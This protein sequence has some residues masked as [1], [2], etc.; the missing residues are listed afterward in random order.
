MSFEDPDNNINE[1][2]VYQ[3]YNKGKDEVP[4]LPAEHLYI[5]RNTSF[6]E[7]NITIIVSVLRK[8]GHLHI[9]NHTPLELTRSVYDCIVSDEEQYA[10]ASVYAITKL[11]QSLE[12]INETTHRLREYLIRQQSVEDEDPR[13]I[14]DEEELVNDLQYD[15]TELYLT[16][17]M[18]RRAFV[19]YEGELVV[20]DQGVVS[21]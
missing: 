16:T 8:L 2:E 21:V 20:E 17:L 5:L 19:E 13:G 11:N 18:R 15:L 9:D 12:L 3:I 10:E 7:G 14:Q 1:T 6:T 4:T